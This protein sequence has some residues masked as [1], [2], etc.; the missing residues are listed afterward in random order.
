MA[1]D[2][3][4]YHGWQVQPGYAT[5]QGVL[6][7]IVSVIEGAP[8]HV[9]GSGR[10]DAGVHAL[11][12]VAAFTLTNPIPPENLRKA[13]NRLLPPAIRV[14]HAEEVGPDFHPRF[15]AVSKTYRYTMYRGEILPPF[16]A[17]YVFHHPYPL[18][19]DE[20]E[21][22]ARSFEGEHEFRPFAAKDE[23]YTNGQ[24]TV[25]RVFSSELQRD[26]DRLIYTVRGA[27]FLKYMV[28]NIMG[29]LIEVGRGNLGP[30]TF[31]RRCGAT[32]PARGLTLMNVEY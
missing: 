10:T 6:Q 22:A 25:R 28:R 24:S 11:G 3:S 19:E 2:G 7:D 21:Q 23:R 18:L 31:P 32:A 30:G 20:M 12:Q 26:G 15:D 8:V 14:M 27:G 29:T 13:I 17:R 5:I 16:E 9:A 1:Y 4:E